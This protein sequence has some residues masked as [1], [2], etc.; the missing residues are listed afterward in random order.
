MRAVPEID[1]FDFYRRVLMILG[2]SYGLVRLVNF[3]WR[4]RERGLAASRHEAMLRHWVELTALRLRI[5]R[6]TLDVLQVGLL[7]AI[8]GYVIW[9]QVEP[10]TP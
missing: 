2:G 4:W 9:H 10:V 6:F 8:L 1:I 7:A 5:R 3:I